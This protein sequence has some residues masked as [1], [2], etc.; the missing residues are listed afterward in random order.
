MGPTLLNNARL[1]CMVVHTLR[2]MAYLGKEIFCLVAAPRL[3]ASQGAVG[4][5]PQKVSQLQAGTSTQE[6]VRST[7]GKA[8][9]VTKRI[10]AAGRISKSWGYGNSSVGSDA[11]TYIP[12]VGLFYGKSTADSPVLISRSRRMVSSVGS[13]ARI[14]ERKAYPGQRPAPAPS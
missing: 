6:N 3:G 9:H 11:A 7:L 13:R 5:C 10:D 12:I 2:E 4:A 14:S 8:Q 1:L